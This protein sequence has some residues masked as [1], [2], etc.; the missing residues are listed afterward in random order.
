VQ[1]DEVIDRPFLGR[2]WAFPP[3]VSGGDVAM[4]IAEKDIEQSIRIILETAPG[5]RVMRPDFGVG[6]RRMVFSPLSF[7]TISVVQFRIE[8]AL[9]LW[10]PRIDVQAVKVRID[11]DRPGWLFIDIRYRVRASNSIAN[12]VYPFYLTEDRQT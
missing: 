1:S 8:Q 12:L 5:E 2:G 7:G 9:L 11:P 4:A 6:L 3:R 10:E